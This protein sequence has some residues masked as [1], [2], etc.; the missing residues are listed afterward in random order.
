MRLHGLSAK[1]TGS[2]ESPPNHF[3]AEPFSTFP[4][5]DIDSQFKDLHVV[6]YPA[7]AQLCHCCPHVP[8]DARLCREAGARTYKHVWDD[9]TVSRQFGVGPRARRLVKSFTRLE[10]LGISCNWNSWILCTGRVVDQV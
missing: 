2:L 4:E 5:S 6:S 9:R 3:L 7:W 8:R 1:V 10:V